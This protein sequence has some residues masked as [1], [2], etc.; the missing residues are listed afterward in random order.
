MFQNPNLLLTAVAF[1]LFLYFSYYRVLKE[2]FDF[3]KFFDI[4]FISLIFGTATYYLVGRGI[5][6][7]EIY[8]PN[9]IWLKATSNV[10]TGFFAAVAFV[11]SSLFL[12]KR[13][14]WSFY[15]FFD[16]LVLSIT[17]TGGFSLFLA[18]ILY[19]NLTLLIWAGILIL[20]YIIIISAMDRF[21][22][23]GYISSLALVLVPLI[24][25]LITKNIY[26]SIYMLVF[27]IFGGSVLFL[28][29][30]QVSAL[31]IDVEL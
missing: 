23:A 15:K 30:R 16:A 25:L 13:K 22:S 5:T 26:D 27:S 12:V 19:N 28:R 29:M 7:L 10:T 4:V 18:V 2:G 6:D 8:N 24:V 3:E 21:I 14:K 20:L 9:S 11:F 1:I 17:V 31:K